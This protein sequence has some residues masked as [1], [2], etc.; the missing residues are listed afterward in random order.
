MADIF[1]SYA[2][3]DRSRAKLF[4]DLL[5]SCG[6][7]VFWDG[8]IKAAA[9]WRDVLQ[10]ELD[11]AGAV[12]VLWSEASVDSDWVKEEAER[13][14]SRL[15]PVR[16]DEVELP[17]GFSG[18]QA[19]NLVGWR[20]GKVEDVDKLIAGVT[21]ALGRPP[22][23]RA[24]IPKSPSQKRR[25]AAAILVAGV[26][27]AAYPVIQWLNRPAPIMSQ[28]IVIDTSQGMSAPFDTAPSKLS[29]AIESLRSRTLPPSEN[30]ALRAFGGE[31]HQDD[32]SRLLVSFGTNRRSRIVRAA[33]NLQPRGQPALAAGVISALA[34]LQPLPN[35]KRIVVLTGHADKCQEEALREIKERIE[36]YQRAGQQITLEVRMIG[37]AVPA[38]EQSGVKQISDAVGGQAYF[39][40]TVKELN[41]VLEYVLE[42]E[43]GVTHVRAVWD[44]V[45]T[46]G[47]SVGELP[48]HMNNNRYDEAEKIA[49]SGTAA[50]LKM[51]PS[52]D[53]LA[54][55]QVSPDFERF[56]T[57]ATEN[58]DLQ[59]QLLQIV[60]TGIREGKTAGER[61]SPEYLK[62]M[63]AWNETMTKYNAN[64]TEMNRLSQQIVK[65]V[66][67]GR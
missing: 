60:G 3:P 57:L 66:R 65:A 38:E 48:Q 58:R 25:L 47:K 8:Q 32:E 53:A 39:V 33:D 44:V 4:A 54:G 26:L 24:K 31:C 23:Q 56:Y 63:S 6:W 2:N 7:S 15:V 40:S 64:M 52:F 27:L 14:R 21:E 37:L 43:P 20:G 61:Q 30:L 13:G 22:K 45:G 55:S 16:I 41:D 11:K 59:A 50:Y 19:V 1:L 18:Q 67:K 17:L 42:F 35:T 49:E 51:K 29:A 28:E 12:V 62:A 10:G 34:D 9:D 5:S 36:A 46:V